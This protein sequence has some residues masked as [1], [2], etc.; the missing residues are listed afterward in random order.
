LE[1]FMPRTHNILSADATGALSSTPV[2]VPSVIINR[3]AGEQLFYRVTVTGGNPAW[4]FGCTHREVIRLSSTE[5]GHPKAVYEWTMS[6][7]DFDTVNDVYTITM[8]FG[9]AIRYQVVTEHQSAGGGL[10]EL[11]TDL[12]F[13]GGNPGDFAREQ[14]QVFA[15]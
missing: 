3:T 8:L 14:L 9:P 11:L 5:P 12:D 13:N 2:N 10:I 15:M 4:V 1:D 6:A 7:S